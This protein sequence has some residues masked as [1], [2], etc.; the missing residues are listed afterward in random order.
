MHS[1]VIG[2]LHGGNKLIPLRD[3]F[4]GRI[5]PRHI[6]GESSISPRYRTVMGL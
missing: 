2:I 1:R 4:A 6:S 3:T 5:E